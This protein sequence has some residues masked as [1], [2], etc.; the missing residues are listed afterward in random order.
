MV[1]HPHPVPSRVPV[2]VVHCLILRAR[3][4]PRCRYVIW[5]TDA[6]A[7]ASVLRA[8]MAP[9]VELQLLPLWPGYHRLI[10]KGEDCEYEKMSD[11]VEAVLVIHGVLGNSCNLSRQ[12]PTEV[13]NKV[14]NNKIASKCKW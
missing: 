5:A 2:G 12:V 4:P 13:Q 7:A 1:L 9:A 11:A 10:R 6:A 8:A 14:N 3:F